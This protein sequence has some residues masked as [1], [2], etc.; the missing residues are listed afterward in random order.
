M[1]CSRSSTV[2]GCIPVV[3]GRSFAKGCVALGFVLPKLVDAGVSNAVPSEYFR[4]WRLFNMFTV[5]PQWY[6]KVS[7]II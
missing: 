6:Q 4:K 3:M 1:R 2:I 5:Y 7:P